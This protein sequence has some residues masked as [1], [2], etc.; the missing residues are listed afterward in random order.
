MAMSTPDA[1]QLDEHIHSLSRGEQLWLIERLARR[2]RESSEEEMATFDRQVAEMA[3]DPAIR[4]ELQ[5]ISA[6]FAGTE[7]DGLESH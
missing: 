1:Q 3:A 6:D 5:A 7:M 4:A 2:L